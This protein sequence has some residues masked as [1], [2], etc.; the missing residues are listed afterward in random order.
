MA[1]AIVASASEPKAA[2]SAAAKHRYKLLI[3]LAFLMTNS[4]FS[5]KY[6]IDGRRFR[7]KMCVF[8]PLV[9]CARTA[10]QR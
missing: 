10:S 9:G 2:L 6:V 3:Q 7:K 1:I 5:F 4:A 8:Q